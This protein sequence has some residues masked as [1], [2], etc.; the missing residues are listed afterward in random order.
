MFKTY[1][2]STVYSNILSKR[3]TIMVTIIKAYMATSI[4]FQNEIK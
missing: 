2:S 4:L 1:K 3:V